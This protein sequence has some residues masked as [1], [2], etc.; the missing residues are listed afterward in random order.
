MADLPAPRQALR[1]GTPVSRRAL[2]TG[3]VGGLALAAV[4]ACSTDD[5]TA[6]RAPSGRSATAPDVAVAT[7]AL[8]EIRAVREAVV[9]TLRRHPDTRP[10]LGPLR[11]LHR[12]HEATLV[13][14]VPDHASPSA[15]PAAYA[16]PRARAKAL[17]KLAGHERRAH[18]ALGNLAMRA[19]SGQFAR[20]LASM[21]AALHQRLAEWPS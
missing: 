5:H 17:T 3:T 20:L 1:T 6:T 21:G 9:A 18:D 12:T 10:A 16:V 14:A 11:A 15:E 8:A 13:D 7:A 4:A 19:E 2:V